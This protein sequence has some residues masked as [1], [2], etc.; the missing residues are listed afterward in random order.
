MSKTLSEKFSDYV[1]KDIKLEKIFCSHLDKKHKHIMIVD[2]SSMDIAYH[3]NNQ[4]FMVCIEVISVVH[5]EIN[6]K[7]GQTVLF[8]GKAL[9]DALVQAKAEDISKKYKISL[10][11][12]SQ[13]HY[14]V[15]ILK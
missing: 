14:E 3:N 6:Y 11:I 4:G 2:I 7:S 1:S 15:K 5:N 9:L 12:K 13:R 10:E 8:G